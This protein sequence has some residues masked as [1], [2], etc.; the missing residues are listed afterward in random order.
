MDDTISRQ[1]AIDEL[2]KM[3]VDCFQADEELVDAVVTTI[4]GLPAA[5]QEDCS[6]CKHGYFGSLQCNNCR[7]RYPS[8]Y[9]RCEDEG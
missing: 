9:E 8:H 6:T 7:V 1:L 3:L 2:I 4:K 5:E